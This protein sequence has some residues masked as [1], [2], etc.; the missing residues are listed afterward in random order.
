MSLRK[1]LITAL[2]LAIA[3]AFSP[4]SELRAAS[5]A[6]PGSQPA[7]DKLVQSVK[8]KKKAYKKAGKR[9]A[10]KRK[11]GR[12]AASKGGSCGTYKYRKKGKCVDALCRLTD[13]A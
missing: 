10:G 11:R 5:P 1:T 2:A 12:K 4:L 8:M 6:S 3:I 9:K 7:S 13:C